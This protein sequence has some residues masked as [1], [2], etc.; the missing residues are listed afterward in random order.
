MSQEFDSYFAE[1]EKRHAGNDFIT[2]HCR[3]YAISMAWIAADL[4][5]PAVKTVLDIGSPS[6]FTHA[7]RHFFPELRVDNTRPADLRTVFTDKRDHY[8]FIINMEVIEHINDLEAKDALHLESYAGDGLK[9][10]VNT[11][12]MAL[13]PGGKMFL[14][15][16]NLSS[17][18]AIWRAML[19]WDPYSYDLHVRELSVNELHHI[20]A[21]AGFKIVHY[22]T[23]DCYKDDVP[24][25]VIPGLRDLLQ[26][27]NCQVDYR[28]QV[29]FVMA[30]KPA[31]GAGG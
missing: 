16:P 6:P 10:F 2:I 18:G 17:Y 26:A 30:L 4:A 29:Q 25:Q 3:R 14:T 19:G 11:C 21:H 9:N 15:T 20:L 27:H 7:V 22:E 31:N 24:I 12:F 23:R 5:L 1:V 28:L 8:D 13:K